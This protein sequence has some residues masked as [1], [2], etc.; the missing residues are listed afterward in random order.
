MLIPILEI[1]VDSSLQP[2][3]GLNQD[4]LTEYSKLLLDSSDFDPVDLFYDGSNY[5]LA[6]G[7]HRIEVYRKAG[8][9]HIP[10]TVREGTRRNA[11]ILVLS[12]TLSMG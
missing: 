11:I 2:R 8:K 1:T 7:F 6:D 4:K 3:N 9:T 10:A 5:W 12:A